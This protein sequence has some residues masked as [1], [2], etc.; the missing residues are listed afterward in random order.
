MS[1]TTGQLGTPVAS[2][3]LI[4]LGGTAPTQLTLMMRALASVIDNAGLV[5]N[6]YDFPTESVVV[7]CFVVGYPTRWE[8]DAAFGQ[9][10][11]GTA[12]FPCWFMVGKT[13]T[14]DARNALSDILSQAGSVKALLDACAAYDVRVTGAEVAEITVSG[15]AYLA[16]KFDC[17]VLG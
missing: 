7:P 12:V 15:V 6:V 17:E 2:P 9:V 3:G 1:P 8:F 13:N 5:A 16:A 10:G 11:V 14:E 4:A